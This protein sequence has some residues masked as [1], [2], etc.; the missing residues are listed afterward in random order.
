M[1]V[2]PIELL[3]LVVVASRYI[4][5]RLVRIRMGTSFDPTVDGF[6]PTVAIVVPMFNQGE[7]IAATIASFLEQDY[8]ASKLQ[9][10]VV[11]DASR[12]DSYACACRAAGGRP[13]VKVLRNARNLGK[14]LSIAHA[15]RETRSEIVVSVDSDVI[16][17][18]HA[19]RQLVRRFVS[20]DI[21][22]VGGRTYVGNRDVNWLTRMAEVKF[23]FS[24]EWLKDLEN[25][26]RSVLCLS[27]CLTAYR[28]S[29]LLELEPVLV[30]R[31]VAGVPIR[32]GEDRFLTRQIL[33]A[34]YRTLFTGDAYCFTEAPTTL[35]AYFAQQ[36]R[37]RRSN[38]IDFFCGLSH[39]WRLHPAIALHFFA[40]R[41]LL[42]AYPLVVVQNVLNDAL[43]N[44]ISL[45]LGVVALLSVVYR[46]ETRHLPAWRRVPS[47]SFLAITILLP[48]NYLMLTPLAL[49]TL[50]SG[51]WE[52]R[53]HTARLDADAVAPAVA[54]LP[55][56]S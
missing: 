5:G 31:A 29:V 19:V 49:F 27:G 17:D 32:Y 8:P 2:V 46:L 3:I 13:Q 52:T 14:R 24:Q 21:G 15:V 10:T 34:R 43:G 1:E 36:L 28:R 53:G 42:L 26:Y 23:Y 40:Q 41:A 35:G 39:V 6:E 18:R 33:K 50:D 51:S 4:V 55:S 7:S 48:A 12:D 37:W 16:L 54:S 47:A 22:A 25:A 56:S 45:H 38:L 30:R 20:P 44:V 9:I 11:D